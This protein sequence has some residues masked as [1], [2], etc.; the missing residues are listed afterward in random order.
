MDKAL[1]AI[2]ESA[3]E[4]QQRFRAEQE[5]QK[6]QRRQAVYLLASGQAPS[7]VEGAELLAVHRHP[8]RAW[9]AA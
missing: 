4:L 7:R 1:P 5:V 2:T 3:E 6:R 8:I 9:L